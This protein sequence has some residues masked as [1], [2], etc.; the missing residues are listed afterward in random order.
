MFL[1]CIKQIHAMIDSET[2]Y[3]KDWIVRYIKNKDLIRKLISS[4]EESESTFHVVKKTSEQEF[5]V[6]PFLDDM[7]EIVATLDRYKENKALVCF[8][9]KDNFDLLINE[10]SRFV[11]V[12]KNFT[13]YFVNPFSKKERVLFI[14][15][16]IH[17]LIADE[18]NLKQGLKSMANNVE[19]TT[20]TEI[21][22]IISS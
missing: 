19:I 18:E 22:K 13:I 14:S 9:T 11:D 7:N 1:N 17:N 5:F 8:H 10:W 21:K 3:L 6:V 4:I 15:P 20:E 12:G 2:K 16:Q